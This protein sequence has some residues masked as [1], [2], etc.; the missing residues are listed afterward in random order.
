MVYV[1]QI[2]LA[3][4]LIIITLLPLY[5]GGTVDVPSWLGWIEGIERDGLIGGYVNGELIYPPLTWVI[6]QGVAIAYHAL[7]I[8][9]FLAF[10][11]SMVVFLFLTS[12]VFLLWTRDFFLTAILH[13]SLI[14]SSVSL[15][16]LDIYYTPTILLAFWALKERKVFLFTVF[17]TISCLIKWQPLIIGPFLLVHIAGLTDIRQWKTTLWFLLRNVA[18]PAG[19]LIGVIVLPF[20]QAVLGSLQN[21]MSHTGLT[22]NALNYNWIVTYYLRV[23]QP[24][25]FGPLAN[26]IIDYIEI[27]DWSADWSIPAV[28]RILFALFYAATLLVFLRRPKSFDN[29]LRFTIL[30]YFSYFTFNIGVHENHLFL[31][32]FLSFVLYWVS[33]RDRYIAL[34]LN[35]ITN[36]NIFLFYGLTGGYPYQRVVGVDVSLPLAIFNVVFFLAFWAMTCLYKSP[37]AETDLAE[38]PGLERSNSPATDSALA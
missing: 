36:I 26:G 15:G 28:S 16:Y 2:L 4:L 14:L 13:L 23:T 10:K 38:Q 1:F 37:H 8:E 12:A 33:P 5:S 31:A 34:M 7:N 21:G 3:I 17:F 30:G 29:L 27:L 35:L 25:R 9:M 22:G 20:G 32:A 24:D 6:L 18:L 11:W 19:V